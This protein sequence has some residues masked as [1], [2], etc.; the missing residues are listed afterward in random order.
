MELRDATPEEF[1]FVLESLNR[2][3]ERHAHKVTQFT[4]TIGKEKTKGFYLVDDNWMVDDDADMMDFDEYFCP[5]EKR[6][7]LC[8]G[9]CSDGTPHVKVR[10]E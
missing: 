1:L 2:I 4:S 5:T 7:V 9:P 10:R 8:S 3:P 6:M